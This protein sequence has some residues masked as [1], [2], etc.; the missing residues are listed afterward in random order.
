M[1]GTPGHG[2]ASSEGEVG[3]RRILA[4]SSAKAGFPLHRFV[5]N[6][7]NERGTCPMISPSFLT[8]TV[9]LSCSFDSS[10]S[11]YMVLH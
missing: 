2:L 3:D 4:G 5:R 7:E 1:P 9:Y 10:G 8:A 11:R 6:I